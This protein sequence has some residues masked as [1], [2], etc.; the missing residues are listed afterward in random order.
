MKVGLPVRPKPDPTLRPWPSD[1]VQ[2]VAATP[3]TV[4]VRGIRGKITDGSCADCDARLAYDSKSIEDALA[5]PQ[6]QGRPLRFICV[7]CCLKYDRSKIE[8][9]IDQRTT[10]GTNEGNSLDE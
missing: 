9:L 4:N 1:V 3:A 2:I 7:Q 10:R 8:C 6:R 5:L